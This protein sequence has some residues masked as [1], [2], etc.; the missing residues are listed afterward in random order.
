MKLKTKIMGNDLA[1]LYMGIYGLLIQII[2]LPVIYLLSN[3][4]TADSVEA[5]TGILIF[6][7]YLFP[8]FS[9]IPLTLALLQIRQRK[10][11]GRTFKKPM[12]GLLVNAVWILAIVVFLVTGYYQ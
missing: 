7:W 5:T 8:L 11:E 6:L 1:A 10:A 3:Y 2:S 4:I 12:A 9:L